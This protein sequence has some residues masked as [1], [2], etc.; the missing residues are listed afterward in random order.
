VKDALGHGSEGR[1]A[2]DVL[3]QGHPKSAPVPVHPNF[4][5]ALRMVRNASDE[6]LVDISRGQRQ[7]LLAATLRQ[8][9]QQMGEAFK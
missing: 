3:A 2:A 9:A 4:D 6:D 7:A 8:K 5:A 1:R